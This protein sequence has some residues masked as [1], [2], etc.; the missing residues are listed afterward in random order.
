MKEI[1]G[2]WT[3]VQVSKG[4]SN[5]ELTVCIGLKNRAVYLYIQL[6]AAVSVKIRKSDPLWVT[7]QSLENPSMEFA[8]VQ[9]FSTKKAIFSCKKVAIVA[10]LLFFLF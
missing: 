4:S 3:L 2:K 7:F 8:L 9:L 10:L 5:Q 6:S 1:Q